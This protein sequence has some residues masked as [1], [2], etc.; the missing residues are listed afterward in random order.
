[1]GQVAQP[2]ETL[3]RRLLEGLENGEQLPL[4]VEQAPTV[5]GAQVALVHAVADHTV[6][7]QGQVGASGAVAVALG[8]WL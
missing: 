1:M 2:P 6:K 3:H 8:S 4:A 7:V 5:Q